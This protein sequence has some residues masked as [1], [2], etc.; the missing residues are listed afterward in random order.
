MLDW[1]KHLV[2]ESPAGGPNR[3][4]SA[5][6]DDLTPEL[7]KLLQHELRECETLYRTAAA[8]AIRDAPDRVGDPA[9]FKEQMLDL[10]R[11]LLVKVFMQIAEGDRAWNAPER[12]MAQELLLH[13]WG[14]EIV[15]EQLPRVLQQV[16]DYADV[17]T[18]ESLVSPF[19][20]LKTLERHLPELATIVV[21]IANLI[22][23][24]DGRVRPSETAALKSIQRALDGVLS[25]KSE[26][27]SQGIFFDDAGEKV[28]EAIQAE[29]DGQSGEGKRKDEKDEPAGLQ[30]S[31]QEAYDEALAELDAL[32]GLEVVKHDIRELASF[33]RVQ[34]ARAEHDL[35]ATD[36]S[37]HAIFQGKPFTRKTIVARMLGRILCFL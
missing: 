3:I 6:P 22:A 27:E 14:R 25:G 32:I 28:A 11:G 19:V 33:L 2:S 7:L 31:P 26:A 17:L 35:P 8:E 37:L 21:R 34:R 16:A 18:W 13:V 36:V 4:P 9:K 1:I 15:P 12:F 24:A 10:H 30:Q 20:R 5:P 23:K 29:T